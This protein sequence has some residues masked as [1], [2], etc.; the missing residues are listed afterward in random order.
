MKYF[1]LLWALAASA[2]M[3]ETNNTTNCFKFKIDTPSNEALTMSEDTIVGCYHF[4]SPNKYLAF[5]QETEGASILSSALVTRLSPGITLK[6]FSKSDGETKL[7]QQEHK[8]VNPLPIPLDITTE[9][10]GPASGIEMVTPPSSEAFRTSITELLEKYKAPADKIISIDDLKTKFTSRDD[11]SVEESYLPDEK[12]P[13]DGY[14]WPQRGAPLATGE[15]SPLAKYD[16]YVK[17]VSG[18]NPNS[19]EWELRRHA[20]DVYWTGHCNGW[21]SATILYGYEDVDLNDERNSNIITS[22]DIQGLRSATSYCTRN[23]FYGRRNYGRPW[24]DVNDIHPHSFHRLLKYYIDQLGKPM[25]YDYNNGPVVDN[26]IISG[27][28]FTYEPTDTPNKFLVKAEL[29]S[30]GYS[31]DELVHEKRVAPTYT[32]EYWYY[33]WVSERGTPYKGEWVNENHHPDFMWVPLRE[34]RCGGENP[35]MHH[36]WVNYMLRKLPQI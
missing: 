3:A 33:L 34:A 29:R 32:R 28:R 13:S 15:D 2:T 26:H 31:V 12:M 14:W 27:Y 16:A 4:L 36:E 21:V 8:L 1:A 25:A 6:H 35:R 24:D 5:V 10:L 23:A 22:S 7:I 19:V 17:S 18:K 20:G 9:V 30:H 11:V